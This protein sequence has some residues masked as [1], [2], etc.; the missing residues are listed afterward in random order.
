[1]RLPDGMEWDK[2]PQAVLD[3]CAQLVK[4]N[5]IEG[6]KKNNVGIVYTP[7]S[8]LKK[9]QGMETGQVGF[10]KEKLVQKAEVFPQ[11]HPKPR[12]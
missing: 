8:N 10:H 5:S 3:D 11:S 4:A 12:R 6:N 2:I 9:T 7:W 1:M